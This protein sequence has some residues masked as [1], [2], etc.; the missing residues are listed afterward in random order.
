MRLWPRTMTGQL[1]ALLLVGLVAA[2][3]IGLML[4]LGNGERIHVISREQMAEHAAIAWRLG[5]L[6]TPQ[7]RAALLQASLDSR[8]YTLD[9]QPHIDAQHQRGRDQ[10]IL[11]QRLQDLL[12]LPADAL[13]VSLYE[14]PE[15]PATLRMALRTPDGHWVNTVQ[16]PVITQ[17]WQRPL[18]FSVPVSTLPVLVIVALFLRRILRP[19]KALAQAAERVSRGEQIDALPVTGPQEARDVTSAFNLMQQRL[20][21]FVEDRTR[22]LAAISHDLR[23][24]IT[25]LRLR[26]ELVDDAALRTA[27]IRTLEEMRVMVEETMHFARDDA[28]AEATQQIDLQALLREIAEEQS[29]QGHQVLLE[30]ATS[31]PYR[32]RPIHLRRA[33]GNLVDNAVRYGQCARL[34]LRAQSDGALTILVDD[35]GP[36]I[37]EAQLEEVFKPFVRLDPARHRGR[38][39]HVGLGLAIARSSVE[40]HGGR[41]LLCNRSGG[42][43]RA[44]V[45]LPA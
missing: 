33:L 13:R 11:R 31:Q 1:L 19:I 15:G 37:A 21:R 25:S 12:A 43:L 2:H 32:C 39:S 8:R 26:A 6:P 3:A 28:H 44:Q 14:S 5:L 23:T 20:R 41:L 34:S 36:G 35:D 29:A 24:P 27:M 38:D 30:E 42:G 16:F 17:G 4:V 9:P 40:A 45:S 18:R 7:A 22:M 10:D